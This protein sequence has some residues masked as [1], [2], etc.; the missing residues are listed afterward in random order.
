MK[1]TYIIF[2]I[3][4]LFVNV[5]FL[6]IFA[7]AQFVQVITGVA[8]IRIRVMPENESRIV[9]KAFEGNIFRFVSE[10]GDWIEIEMFSGDS[11][12]IHR[13]QV[14]ILT[15][16]VSAPFSGDFCPE[17]KERLEEAKESSGSESDGITQNI[18]FD[19]YALDIFHEFNLQP[20]VYQLFVSR[21]IDDTEKINWQI[22]LEKIESNALSVPTENPEF[23]N[24]TFQENDDYDFRKTNWG[25]SKE[26]VKEAEKGNL[27]V[28]EDV[29]KDIYKVY[30][31]SL[32]YQGELNGIECEIH[33]QFIKDRLITARYKRT[34][35]LRFKEEY[36]NNYYNLKKFFI[37]IY[38]KP[39][40]D[41]IEMIEDKPLDPFAMLFWENPSD[42]IYLIGLDLMTFEDRGK[43]S[44]SVT[45]QSEEG[46]NMSD[47]LEQKPQGRTEGKDYQ[48]DSVI[49]ILDWTNR[50]SESGNYYYIEGKVKNVGSTVA[51]SVRVKI[52]ALDN[53]GKLVSLVEG[54]VDPSTLKLDQIGF[55]SVMVNYK[56]SIKKFSLNVYWN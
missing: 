25:M 51:K 23:Y 35:E 3:I 45:Y 48:S 37:N 54:Y 31:G 18:L 44:W 6:S 8:E 27:F 15:R 11:R 42:N 17:L 50:R 55:F 21:C 43:I 24:E 10:N 38:G 20:V 7:S 47:K 1:N 53:Y 12:Y 33:Y 34:G 22:N 39:L 56:S 36:I 46:A 9:C 26:E 5:F 28:E 14:E 29:E 52:E 49:E 19:R 16:G 13:S 40:H 2:F 4:L 32:L 30:D 41:G